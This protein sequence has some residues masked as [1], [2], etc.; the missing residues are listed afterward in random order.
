MGLIAQLLAFGESG[1]LARYKDTAAR[2]NALEASMQAMS[3]ADLAALTRA[4]RSRRAAGESLDALLPDAFAAVREAS[5][6]T[7]GLRHFDVQLIGGMALHDGCIAQM[8]T[9]EG[10]TLVSV[11]AGYLNALDGKGVHIVT[12]NDYLARRDCSQMGR[13]YWLLGM[14]T[15][16]IQNGMQPAD[17]ALAYQ[18]D[19]TYGTNAEFGFDYL[20]DNMAVRLK[21]RV[22]RGHAFAIV[23]EVDSI[24]I[25]EARTPLIISGTGTCPAAAYRWFA[26]V[27]PSLEE[28]VHFELDEVKRTVVA[29]E[30]GIEEVERALGIEDIYAD[31]SGMLAGHLN[32]ALAAQ[33][34]Y[35][36]DVD[37]VVAEDQVKLVDAFTGRI[38]EG[39]RFSDGL[40]QALEAKEGVTVR[41]ESQTLATVTLQNYFRL[42]D[43]LAGMTGT[44]MTEEAEFRQI[45]GLEVVA[46]PPNRPLARKDHQ[47]AVYAT[48][49]A[50][51]RA[52]V[53]DVARCNAAGQPCLVGT[54][55]IESSERLSRLL[56]RR[57]IK[58][59][60]LNAKNHEREAA[61]IAQAGRLGA[62]T[63]A[64]NMAGRGTDILLGGNPEVLA[65]ERGMAPEVAC[66]LCA[67]ERERVREL[68]GLRVIGTE[69]HESRRI[70]DQ[71]RGRAGRQGDPGSSQFYLS[72][73]DDLFASGGVQRLSKLIGK[74]DAPD[75]PDS[76]PLGGRLLQNSI[77]TAQRNIEA[78]HFAARKNL[79]EYDDVMNLQRTAVYAE[80]TAILNGK[81]IRALIPSIIS[82]VADGEDAAARLQE[83]YNQKEERYGATLMA[84]LAA[85]IMLRSLDRHWMMHLQEMDYLKTG[86]GLRAL[87][88]RDPLI[89]YKEEAYAA[90]ER[91]TAVAYE[92]FLHTLLRCKLTV[93]LKVV[94]PVA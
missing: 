51:Y 30:A 24:L 90:F 60:L 29:T 86:I 32:Q 56:T 42:Y 31:A 34:L 45:Y 22:Q 85:N 17:R 43:K 25:D 46:V 48:S 58:H 52:V 75:A 26:N 39:R 28:G 12:V 5:V 37:Y 64:T 2:I 55:S 50:K 15:G 69:R 72:L 21:D 6:R 79:L 38:M 27:M 77:R 13:I 47:D 59:E 94:E 1:R 76:K 33:F 73:E 61:I 18:A 63:I 70:D 82:G 9:G 74:S 36:R 68:G 92:D 66:A 7:L 81:D 16:L 78:A 44:A 40:H 87:G 65:A 83:A 49:D 8:R 89:E 20:R 91:M 14:S 93:E 62:V 3:D 19:V 23:D 53:E 71:L 54:T 41:E 4:L 88:K 10:K 57:G 11:L 80:R 84:G 67:K 35:R